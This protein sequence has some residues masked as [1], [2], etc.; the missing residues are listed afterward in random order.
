MPR[1]RLHEVIVLRA[2]KERAKFRVEL[3]PN[4]VHDLRATLAD[5]VKRDGQPRTRVGEYSLEIRD[6]NGKKIAG[7]V[8]AK[9]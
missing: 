3:D 5:A 4:Y 8:E 1:R 6:L 7:Y 9:K 2:G